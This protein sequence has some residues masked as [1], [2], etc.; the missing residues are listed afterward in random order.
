MTI[1]HLPFCL[2][3]CLSNTTTK[4]LDINLYS[5]TDTTKD[6]LNGSKTYANNPNILV[7]SIHRRHPYHNVIY[8]TTVDGSKGFI[9]LEANDIEESTNNTDLPKTY[10]EVI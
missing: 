1:K 10:S 4:V 2:C 5:K 7:N 8:A 9:K 3:L 6:N